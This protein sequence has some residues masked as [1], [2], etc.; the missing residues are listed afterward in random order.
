MR[1]EAGNTALLVI[2]MQEKLFSAMPENSRGGA[3]KAAENLCFLARELG[4]PTLFTEQYAKGLGPTLPGLSG[5]AGQIFAK[6]H[7]SAM[8]EPGFAERLGGLCQETGQ[9]QPHI[10]VCGQETHICVAMTVQGLLAQGFR[11]TV[12]HDACLSRRDEDKRYG[13][14]WMAGL[15]ASVLPSETV[16]FGLIEKAGTPIFKEIS[17]R[18]R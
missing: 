4:M 7:F 16:L 2:D 8:L 10:L 15:G 11:V 12:L 6:M 13:L 9:G 18:I 5:E 3:L 14:D 1:F 17:R